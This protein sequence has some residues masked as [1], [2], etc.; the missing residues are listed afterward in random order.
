VVTPTEAAAVAVCIRWWSVSS[1]A[2]VVLAL[3]RIFA[4]SMMVS[5]AILFTG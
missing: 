4:T 3:P 2:L 1:C 5:A